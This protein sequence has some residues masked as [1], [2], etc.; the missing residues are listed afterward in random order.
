[1]NK[2]S[3]NMQEKTDIAAEK[4]KKQSKLYISVISAVVVLL[5]AGA[6]LYKID[7]IKNLVSGNNNEVSSREQ[8]APEHELITMLDEKADKASLLRLQEQLISTQTL[9]NELI[10]QKGEAVDTA[11][12]N[13]RIDNLQDLLISS[14]NGKADAQSVL[15]I[16]TRTDKLEKEVERISRLGNEGAILLAAT[17]MIKEN[18][19]EGRDFSFEAGVLLELAGEN[20]RIAEP[21]QV[22]YEAADEGVATKEDL[23]KEFKVIYEELSKPQEKYN[24]DWKDRLNSKINEFISVSKTGE[25]AEPLNNPES[26]MSAVKILAEEQKFMQIAKLIKGSDDVRFKTDGNLQNWLS[27]VMK[28]EAF[29]TAISKVSAYSL[30]LMKVNNLLQRPE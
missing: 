5:G 23:G 11:V 9:V 4:K 19:A 17:M 16:V 28:K 14:V 21:L 18:A 30:T 22:I 26:I 3:E 27:K 13:Q 12:L 10:M 25:K 1:M 6:V 24:Q 15:G 7:D 20:S 29:D 2:K 8:A